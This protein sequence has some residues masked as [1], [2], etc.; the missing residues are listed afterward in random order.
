MP[1]TK[2]VATIGPSTDSPE[3]IESMI[4][5]G[6]NVFRFNFSHAD[7]A[8]HRENYKK[9]RLISEQLSSHT[10]ILCD[11]AGPKI[12]LGH[13]EGELNLE[14]G[15]ILTFY[16]DNKTGENNCV[17]INYPLI[18]DDLH[19]GEPIYLADGTIRV[20]VMSKCHEYIQTLVEVGG[21]LTSRKGVN[22]PGST[23]T[24]DP[25]TQKDREDIA[26]C[27]ELGVD[28]FAL[29]FVMNAQNI[30]NAKEF[31]RS[32]HA[33]IPVF[34]KIEKID[35]VTNLDSILEVV[36]GVMVARGDLG[37][38]FGLAKVPITQ[39][40]IIA[41]A[42]ERHI[43]VITAT[44]MLTSMIHSPFPT[45]AEVSD[46]AN[47][48][49]DGT[50]AVMLSDETT[51]GEYPL[52]VIDMIV[53]TLTEIET[54]YPYYK[55]ID[56]PDGCSEH[57]VAIAADKLAQGVRAEAVIVF[58]S[59]GYS[60]RTTAKY[61]PKAR[62]IA[63]SPSDKILRQLSVVWGIESGFIIEHEQNSDK[64]VYDFLSQ[65]SQKGCIEHNKNYVVIM[66]HPHCQSGASNMIR[67]LNEETINE[68]LEMFS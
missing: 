56:F 52:E 23:L 6:V 43:P 29:S 67:L 8:Y 12:R 53:Q 65:A 33:D 7:H 20:S 42:N 66:G 51:V 39:K 13:I 30:L 14:K 60:A 2:I 58:T 68:T 5:K 34:A 45:R 32:C 44:Q 46:I 59:S 55:N 28:F 61:R 35:A 49:L 26:F 54:I 22:F 40:M 16:K 37:V 4:R 63:N 64:I 50:D 47:A 10:A 21:K 19:V 11:I 25:L 1:R 9:I 62:I 48:A 57:A 24:I 41:K 38:E 18:L 3:M 27:C 15:D 17:T 36:D 31:I